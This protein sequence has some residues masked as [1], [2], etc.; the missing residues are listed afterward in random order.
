MENNESKFE[1]SRRKV[2]S[3]HLVLCLLLYVYRMNEWP[4][5]LE[6]QKISINLLKHVAEI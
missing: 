5:R 6:K 1:Y 2:T 4:K 3:A